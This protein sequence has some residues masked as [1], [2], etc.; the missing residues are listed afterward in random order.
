MI[1][2][3]LDSSNG[4]DL[5]PQGLDLHSRVLLPANNLFIRG[6]QLVDDLPVILQG[7]ERP[8]D[9]SVALQGQSLWH[10]DKSGAPSHPSS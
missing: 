9:Q 3:L 1:A 4:L 5:Y 7:S 2:L 10:L 8:G 6:F